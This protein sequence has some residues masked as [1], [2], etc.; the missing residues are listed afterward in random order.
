MTTGNINSNYK[1]LLKEL[2]RVNTENTVTVYVPSIKKSTKFKALTVKQQKDLIKSASDPTLMNMLFN[3]VT[4]NIIKDNSL[5]N[6]DFKLHDKAPILIAL[7]AHTVSSTYTASPVSGESDNTMEVDLLKHLKLIKGIKFDNTTSKFTLSVDNIVVECESPSLQLD[8]DITRDCLKRISDK[9][10]DVGDITQFKVIETVGDMY[11]YELVKYIDNIVINP[12]DDDRQIIDFADLNT[13]QKVTVFE[14]LPM[15]L[16]Q[17]FI[18]S[19]TSYKEYETSVT[20]IEAG[21]SEY[22]I[23]LDPGFFS[24]E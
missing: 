1:N 10:T 12:E 15:T 19:V 11:A 3:I 4:N 14:A 5:D 16:S 6:I 13:I 21:E 18:N 20:V 8:T 24:T 17:K 2:D 22:S 9:S 23:T 7:R